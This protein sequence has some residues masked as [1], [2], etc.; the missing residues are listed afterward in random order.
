MGEGAIMRI[1]SCIDRY[2]INLLLV[3]CVLMGGNQASAMITGGVGNS[4]INDPGWPK[5]AAEVFNSSHR[6]AWWEDPPFGGGRWHSECKGNTEQFKEAL[7]GFGAIEHPQKRLIV[8]PGKGNSFWLDKKERADKVESSSQ[9]DWVFVVW[10]ND[11]WEMQA[12][13]PAEFSAIS[14]K[15]EPSP[16]VELIVYTGGDIDW[17]KVTVPQEIPVVDERPESRGFSPKDGNVVEGSIRLPASATK[18]TPRVELQSVSP[19]EQGGYDYKVVK[20]ADADSDGTFI[21][22]DIGSGWF[23]VVATADGFASRVLGYLQTVEESSWR[24]YDTDLAPNATVKGTVM[25]E[26]SKPLKDAKVSL[27]GASFLGERY[28]LDKPVTATSDSNGLFTLTGLLDGQARISVRLDGY[29]LQ[30]LPLKV[31]MPCENL[32]L[33]LMKSSSV[34]IHVKFSADFKPTSDA[35]Y[36]ISMEPEEGEVVGKWSGSAGVDRENKARFDHVPPGKYK[37]YGWPN[38]GRDDQRTDRIAVELQGG[39]TESIEIVAK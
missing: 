39:V 28:E 27:H 32:D 24:K 37:V 19:S 17:K 16:V 15:G 2:V 35:G 26:M 36:L 30:G 7:I 33:K 6:I 29:V 1:M 8:R 20:T 31:E 10:Q 12:K 5:G 23:R 25:D 21:I 4:P 3:V 38:P 22:K 9:V 13:L 34:V 18:V 11:R 14:K